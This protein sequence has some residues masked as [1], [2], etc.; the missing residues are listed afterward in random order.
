M[1]KGYLSNRQKNLRIGIASYTEN[2]TVLEV[3]GKVGI[4]TTNATSKLY[5]DGDTY[6]TGILTANRIFSGIYGEF[7]GGSFSGTEIVGTALSIS[8]I[9]TLGT[10]RI[11]SGIIT[12]T[13]G[14]VTYYGD[15]SN[16]TGV[17]G[18]QVVTQSTVST[19]VYPTFAN[20]VGV[21]SIGI[22]TTQFVF[23]PSTGNVG[24]GTTNPTSKLYVDGDTYITGIL[25]ANRIFSGIYGEFTGG[26]FS[27]TNIVGTSL[28][29]SG[30]STLGIVTSGD[31]FSTGIVTASSFVGNLTGTATTATN[32]ADA[33][34]ITTGT[35]NSSRLSGS[36]GINVS[37]ATTAGVS[38]ALQYP[39]TFE[40]TGDIIASPISFDGTGNVS[41]AA[42][43]QPNSV[44]LITDTTGDFVQS[45]TGTSNQITV[46]GGTGEGSTP[47][48][49]IPSQFTAPQDVTVTRDLQVN[50][51]L[52][53]NGNITIGGTSAT[54]FTTEFK[55]YDPDI[56][57]GFRT[58]GS[59]NDISTDNTANH[60][61]IA[62]AST[63]GNPLVQLY[64]VG[65]GETNPATYKKIM[66]FK[67]NTGAFTGLGTDAWLINYAVGIGSTQFPSGTRLAAGSVQ[68]TER[69]L[70]VVRNIN[71][72]GIV[73]AS[74]FVGAL[75]GTS[76]TATNLADA[77]NITTG[78]INSARLSGSYDINVS[79]A[80]TAGIATV[81]QGLTGTPNIS[82]SNINASGVST[83]GGVQI[84]S[85]IVTA[86]S[87]IITYYGDGSNLSGLIPNTVQN[88]SASSTYYPLLSPVNS[89]SISSLA[90]SSSNLVF[91]PSSGNLGIGTTNPTRNLHVQGDVIITGGLYDTNNVVGTA[92]SVLTSTGAGVSWSASTGGITI[93]DDTSTNAT[94]YILFDDVT[95]G[96]T[97]V[98][99]VSS[100]K[101]QFNPSTGTLS[102][103]IFTSL[104]DESQKENIRVIENPIEITKQ[105]QGVRFNWK[106]TQSDSMGLIAQ[107]VEN[108]LP[109]VVNTD[110][111]GIKSVN[112]SSLVGL[113]IET[114]KE[115]QIRI[116]NLEKKINA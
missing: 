65:I 56:V 12:A 41:L 48:L 31:I 116:E 67:A 13:S 36:Y 46:T 97:S 85:G 32:L 38:T 6:I 70:A 80:N 14:V 17:V 60:G 104:S 82:V 102:A 27:G 33:A 55:V 18:T 54:L 106:N 76:T 20:E 95:S 108:V 26:S 90:V 68:F 72:S 4:G 64:D 111:N 11:S 92:G 5:V 109:E 93:T 53:V 24:I 99:N 49:S 23:I 101:L 100:T 113:L 73:T 16:L 94:R 25:T 39:R 78:T 66:W 57:L 63:E 40:I 28:S 112:Y 8:G 21:S 74:S 47:T 81:S 62:I 75:T 59:G 42:T 71:A 43:I 103:T 7:T 96:S 86:A 83:L 51:N 10:V 44:A 29:I 84:S 30:I 58:D 79:Y 105:L 61:G 9:S 19:P 114:I 115:Q 69:D 34:N 50:R 98:A 15:G 37:Y 107:E 110:E 52:N 22:S 35:I 87:G 91:I 2:N 3:V 77:A 45:I 88:I 1:A 89:G